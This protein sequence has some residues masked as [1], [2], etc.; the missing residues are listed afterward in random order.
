MS[1][2]M[3]EQTNGRTDGC[4]QVHYLPR[5][6]VDKNIWIQVI[7]DLPQF[8]SAHVSVG[9]SYAFYGTAYPDTSYPNF[10]PYTANI[11][12]KYIGSSPPCFTL[13]LPQ[14]NVDHEMSKWMYER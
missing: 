7:L 8:L 1:G 4:Y 10:I 14:R 11:G 13:M 3:D 2:R 12:E 6:A 9:N 5:F